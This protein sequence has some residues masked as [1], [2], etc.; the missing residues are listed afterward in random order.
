MTPEALSTRLMDTFPGAVQT[1][2]PGS[3]QI[4]T[5]DFRLLVLLSEDQ[6]WLRVLV[7]IAP[8][9]DAQPFLQE[10]LEANFDETQE[11]RYA[12]HQDVVW[13]VFQHSLEGLTL[14]DLSSAIQRMLF[15]KQQG[16]DAAFNQFAEKQIRQIIQMSKRQGL[17]LESTLQT[18]ERFYQ[19]GV[20]GDLEM[21]ARSREETMAA[22]Q[23]QLE[24][25]WNEVEP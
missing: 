12:F 1:L 15:L 5:P 16:M 23:R 7:P 8:T 25:L 13:S 14:Q 19:E 11:T 20:M 18:L 2:S 6:T 22:W 4:E 17:S 3:F 9:Q 10:L 21:G 24:R